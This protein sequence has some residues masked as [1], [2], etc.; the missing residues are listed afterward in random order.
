MDEEYFK[1]KIAI[2]K[3]Q[4]TTHPKELELRIDENLKDFE[5]KIQTKTKRV[6]VKDGIVDLNKY[7]NVPIKILWILKEA[8]SPEDDLD[9]MRCCLSTLRDG[10]G[11]HSGWG[12]TFKPITYCVYGIFNNQDWEEIPDVNGNPEVLEC[13]KDIAYINIKKIAGGSKAN[14]A[15]VK[16]FYSE[17]KSLIHEQIKIIDPDVIIFGTSFI[18]FDSIDMSK[19]ENF[20]DK[21]YEDKQKIHL[22][23]YQFGNKLILATYHPNNRTISQKEYCNSII[24]AVN[25]W[26]KRNN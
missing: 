5:N 16:Q 12:S 24:D 25:N 20:G 10:N 23:E 1:Q 9:D 17:Y 6:F 15:L 13:L 22:H 7:L 11:I 19:F 2:M 26:K 18:V 8:N 14:P 3:K 4:T 21:V